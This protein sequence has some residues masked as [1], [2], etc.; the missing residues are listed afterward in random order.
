MKIFDVLDHGCAVK[1]KTGYIV[2]LKTGRYILNGVE[3]VVPYNGDQVWVDDVSNIKVILTSPAP[4][5]HYKDADG[6]V[7]TKEQFQA[8][9]D[10]RSQ[11]YDDATEEYIYPDIETEFDIRKR[12]DHLITGLTAVY[13]E[14]ERIVEDVEV[15]VIGV[16]EDTGSAYI[17]TP[18]QLGRTTFN[19]NSVYKVHTGR[20]ARDAVISWHEANKDMVGELT[21]LDSSSNIR[22]V[23]VGGKY[24]TNYLE[25]YNWCDKPSAASYHNTLEDAK[26]E[27]Y[28]VRSIVTEHFDKMCRPKQFDSVVVYEEL[29]RMK[30]QVVVLDV[31][32]KAE[33]DKRIILGIIDKLLDNL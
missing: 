26:N 20:I 6:N 30:N 22:F 8:A 10:E 2:G 24:M 9:A 1:T 12:T 17:E 31:K 25:K 13:G 32:Q 14:S 23:K 19:Q 4:F 15:V 3:V 28:S 29:M 33:K 11:Y 18:Y 21:G 7:V 16:W 27:E 5:L